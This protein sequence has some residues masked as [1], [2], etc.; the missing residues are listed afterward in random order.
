VV[1]SQSLPKSPPLSY[2]TSC[3][4]HGGSLFLLLLYNH[5]RNTL[6]A[7]RLAALELL[8]LEAGKRIK[9]GRKQQEDGCHNQAGSHGPNADPLYSAHD[10]VDGSAHV[11]RAELPNEFVKLWRRRTDAKEERYLNKDND[12]GAHQANNTECNDKVGVEDVGNAQRKAQEYTQ[13]SGPLTVD[14]EIPRLELLC[15]RH[16]YCRVE[17]CVISSV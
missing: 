7:K 13:N 17:V 8:A 2:D 1:R 10:E 15:E 4:F 16:D 9:D 5:L 11:V 6:S 3:C 12:E 14:T